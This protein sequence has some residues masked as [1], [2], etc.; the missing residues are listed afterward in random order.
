MA[1]SIY[2]RLNTRA[3]T[4]DPVQLGLLLESIVADQRYIA[5]KLDAD[6]VSGLDNDYAAGLGT[7]TK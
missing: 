1:E 7:R 5:E 6:A 3:G 2:R 4:V